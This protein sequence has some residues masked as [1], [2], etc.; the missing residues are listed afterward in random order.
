ML[1]FLIF[2]I[3]VFSSVL[4]LKLFLEGLLGVV[5]NRIAWLFSP[6]GCE[7]LVGQFENAI[8]KINELV[9]FTFLLF[10]LF[11]SVS[12][13]FIYSL[14]IQSNLWFE[15]LFQHF[16]GGSST[17]EGAANLALFSISAW[18]LETW[19]PTAS[20]FFEH[21]RFGHRV[22]VCG[23]WVLVIIETQHQVV[24]LGLLDLLL[25]VKA[26]TT[27]LIKLQAKILRFLDLHLLGCSCL[28]FILSDL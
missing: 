19:K 9:L 16:L 11:T 2:A 13:K 10:A 1:L 21:F 17:F 4:N 6:H 24:A 14:N 26:L 3:T 25:L 15:I 7:T 27:W 20:R 23:L 28:L 8:F 18:K 5:Y 12:I 22:E